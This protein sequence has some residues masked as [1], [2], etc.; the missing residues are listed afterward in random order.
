MTDLYRKRARHYDVTA[1]LFYLVGFREW[2]YRKRA[3]RALDLHK[4]DTVVEIGCGTGLNFALLQKSVGVEGKIIGVDLTDAMLEQA[5]RRVQRQGWTNVALVQRDMASYEFPIGVDGILSTFAITASP[6]YDD[7]IRRGAQ[8][9]APGKRFVIMELKAPTRWPVWLIKFGIF[10]LR[11]FG[12]TL[13]IT[14]RHPWESMQ[15]YLR[16][17][18]LTELYFGIAYIVSGAAG[19]Q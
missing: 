18:S 13:E 12:A 16:N 14:I 2:A 8:A 9:L 1:N 7:V 15:K 3:V 11:P 19:K 5:K 6:S 17:A 4:G 10:F